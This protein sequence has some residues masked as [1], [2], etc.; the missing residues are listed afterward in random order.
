[1][2]LKE[3]YN[4]TIYEEKETPVETKSIDKARLF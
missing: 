2:E 1:M 4:F 3:I